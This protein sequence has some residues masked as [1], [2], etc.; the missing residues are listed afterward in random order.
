M[1][2]IYL[3]L[4]TLI[5]TDIVHKKMYFIYLFLLTLI[6]TDIVHKNMYFILCYFYSS[7]ISINQF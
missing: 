1:Y 2:F 7:Y 5:L 4:L 6:L 3:F